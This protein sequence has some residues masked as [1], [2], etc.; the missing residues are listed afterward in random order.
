MNGDG[1]T[2]NL[3]SVGF[4]VWH[5]YDRITILGEIVFPPLLENWSE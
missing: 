1:G 5:Y 3:V 2:L 4:A